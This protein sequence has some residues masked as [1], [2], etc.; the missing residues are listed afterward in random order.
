MELICQE[1]KSTSYPEFIKKIDPV[2]E[3]EDPIDNELI[4]DLYE[5][6][7]DPIEIH[8]FEKNDKRLYFKYRDYTPDNRA[9]ST[10]KNIICKIK[11]K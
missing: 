9:I 7:K 3:G 5:N 1:I 4:S 6:L 2:K 11:L 10:I 8:H